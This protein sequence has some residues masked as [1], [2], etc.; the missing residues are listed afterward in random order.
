MLSVFHLHKA[1]DKVQQ[2]PVTYKKQ[3]KATSH[4]PDY[5]EW[6]WVDYDYVKQ[7]SDWQYNSKIIFFF[8]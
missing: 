6:I 7:K 1:A 3:K 8:T 2:H 5:T 4:Y